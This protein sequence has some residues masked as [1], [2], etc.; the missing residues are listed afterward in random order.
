MNNRVWSRNCSK[1]N[2]K[3]IPEDRCVINIGL[4]VLTLE[5]PLRLCGVRAFA[6]TLA[7][8]RKASQR[9]KV[10]DYPKLVTVS[11]R[12]PS[13]KAQAAFE[14]H[15]LQD[16]PVEDSIHELKTPALQSFW[17]GSF[18]QHDRRRAPNDTREES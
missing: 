11:S 7:P 18:A 9:R 12:T 4:S 17:A 6:Q 13:S 1:W 15:P 8:R 2:R 14:A 5:A 16:R 10:A 3:V